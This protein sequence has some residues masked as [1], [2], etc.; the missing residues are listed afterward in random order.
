MGNLTSQIFANIYLHELDAFI[1]HNLREDFYVRYADD[2]VILH[3]DASCLK[4]NV[5]YINNFLSENLKLQLHPQK[6]SIRKIS[7]GV[8]FLG[9]ICM[10]HH[11]LI[12]TKTKRRMLRKMKERIAEFQSGTIAFANF[13]QTFQ[14]YLGLLQ[15]TNSKTPQKILLK[16]NLL[17]TP[18]EFQRADEVHF[19]V[20]KKFCYWFL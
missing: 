9:Y 7:R 16:N 1:K 15:Q 4:N 19:C 17:Q 12:R 3:R 13:D 8:D 14:S 11:R 20:S 10:P 5:S 18:G 6:I 2:F